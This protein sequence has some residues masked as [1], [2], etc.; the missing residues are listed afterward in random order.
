VGSTK[1]KLLR[2]TGAIGFYSNRSRS[3][4]V[5]CRRESNDAADGSCGMGV[6]RVFACGGS[7][8]K[9]I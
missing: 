3:T 1:S 5:H 7:D 2:Q 8:E 9:Q 4:R 6:A